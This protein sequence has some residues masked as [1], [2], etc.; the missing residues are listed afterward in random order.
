MRT[1]WITTVM[2]FG[3]AA[4]AQLF[5]M[6][7][8]MNPG[9]ISNIMIPI[10]TNNVS[11]GSDQEEAQWE[12]M[13][14]CLL[15]TLWHKFKY[16]VLTVCTIPRSTKT[17]TATGTRHNEGFIRW[18]NILRNLASRNAGRVILIDIEHELRGMDQARLTTDGI[19]FDSIEGHPWLNRVFQERLDEM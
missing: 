7:E 11:G 3:S 4:I 6:M 5:R 18:N 10:G 8:L 9:S 17:L 14:V 19:H 16:T 13:M 1:T 12:S 2:A 15:T